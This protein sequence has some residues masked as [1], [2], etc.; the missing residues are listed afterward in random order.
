[1][2]IRRATSDELSRVDSLLQ[3]AGLQLPAGLPLANV[4]VAL[5]DSA[6][7]GV[8]ALEVAGLQAIVWPPAVGPSDS[9]KSVRQS[10]F[11][12]LLARAQELSLRELYLLAEKDVAFFTGVGFAQISHEAAPAGIRSTRAY[13]DQCSETTTLMRL[14]LVSRFV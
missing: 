7:I 4:L 6:V 8:I 1:M 12:S 14:Q 5:E 9:G 11:Q 13:R 10:L 3:T 2:L